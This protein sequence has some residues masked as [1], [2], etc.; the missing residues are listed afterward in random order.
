M[1]KITSYFL[2]KSSLNLPSIFSSLSYLFMLFFLQADTLCFIM[3]QVVFLFYVFEH[4]WSF[5]T[6]PPKSEFQM[7]SQGAHRLIKSSNQQSFWVN[8]KYIHLRE[9]RKE[10]RKDHCGFLAISNLLCDSESIDMNVI[11]N[12][13]GS[14]TEYFI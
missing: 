6:Q 4:L 12:N 9:R 10:E 7:S 8:A 3:V 11:L 2:G 14:E 5:F 1:S 13:L